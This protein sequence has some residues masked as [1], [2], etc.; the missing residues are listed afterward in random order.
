MTI[1][2]RFADLVDAITLWMGRLAAALVLALVALVFYNV[3]GR[4]IIGGSPIWL[5]ELEWHIM[6]PAMLIGV[7]VLLKDGGH[8][9]VDM[10]Y[11][12][13]PRR[14]QHLF[15]GISMLLGAA[16]AV[17]FIKYSQGFL[18]SSWSVYEGSPDPGGMSGRYLLKST[19][20]ICFALMAAQC[21]ANAVRHFTDFFNGTNF[22]HRESVEGA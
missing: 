9:R 3:I 18:E 1:L 13:F 17:L 7:T 2:I 5:Q 20:P 4:Y 22:G 15:D 19:L 8:V 21:L 16:I 10:L 11:A 12:K 6:A 14:F